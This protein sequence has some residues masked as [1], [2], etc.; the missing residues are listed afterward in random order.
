MVSHGHYESASLLWAV[1]QLDS[2]KAS[3]P[4]GFGGSLSSH[5]CP[6]HIASAAVAWLLCVAALTLVAAL[7]L[8]SHK[9]ALGFL[10]DLA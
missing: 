10:H 1:D 3:I 2:V 8:P 9:P 4:G 7:L 6:F 5:P